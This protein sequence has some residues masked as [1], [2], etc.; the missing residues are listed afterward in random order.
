MTKLCA[1]TH[2]FVGNKFSSLSSK[3]D[4]VSRRTIHKNDTSFS[5]DESLIKLT[6]YLSHNL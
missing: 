1:V 5:P 3:R 6:L 4:R 2:V